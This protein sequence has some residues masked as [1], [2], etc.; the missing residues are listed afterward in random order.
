LPAMPGPAA[1]PPAGA[2]EPAPAS[3][4]AEAREPAAH[5]GG[6]GSGT[7]SGTVHL[8]SG[9]LGDAFVYVDG[10]RV[11]A[12]HPGTIE[13][14]QRSKQFSP[15]VAVVQAGTRVLFPNEDKIFHNVF[16]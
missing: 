16:S 3:A 4:T 9:A 13:I 7:I 5:A 15:S 12:S 11:V 1:A 14:K 2:R 6:A 8:K 10:P